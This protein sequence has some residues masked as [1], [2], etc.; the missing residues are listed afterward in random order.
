VQFCELHERF[1]DRWSA[2]NCTYDYVFIFTK[3]LRIT[4]N[5]AKHP[6]KNRC[7]RRLF[8]LARE[9][10]TSA[11]TCCYCPSYLLGFSSTATVIVPD[12]GHNKFCIA[13]PGT[14][15]VPLSKVSGPCSDHSK[16]G[17]QFTCRPT[18]ASAFERQAFLRQLL[19]CKVRKCESGSV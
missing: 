15:P 1:S 6:I 5:I 19:I 18:A 2:P 7:S 12:H 10:Y 11:M 17:L 9:Q 16:P 8:T 13:A 3:T 4:L 14:H